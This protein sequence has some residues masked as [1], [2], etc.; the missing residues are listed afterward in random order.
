MPSRPLLRAALATLLAL[1]SLGTWA[2]PP[3]TAAGRGSAGDNDAAGGSTIGIRLVEVPASRVADPRAQRYIVDHV[4]PGT[5]FTRRFEVVTNATRPV[6]ARLYTGAAGIEKGRFTFAPFGATNELSSWITL[7]RSRVRLGPGGHAEVKATVRVPE[8]ATE[9]ER[10]AVIWAEVSSSDPGPK[11][12]VALV[13][14]V[15][16]RAYLDVGPGGEL[17]SDFEIGEIVPRR[18]ADGRPAIVADVANTG[19]RA[20][21]LEGQVALSG[22]PSALSAGPFPIERGTTL[23]PGDRGRITV[24]LGEDLPNGPWRFRLTLRSGE[25]RRT[26]TGTLSFPAQAGAIGLAASLDSPLAWGLAAAGALALLATGA[27]LLVRRHLRRRRTA[28]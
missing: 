14:R 7:D 22:G 1:A 3:A 23:A 17:P 19:H 6:R 26:A 15:G 28:A 12:N 24:T 18:T 21:D 5:T 11:G 2:T 10:Y 4:N 27:A 16:I 8:Q 20:V 9:G 25:L 13:N